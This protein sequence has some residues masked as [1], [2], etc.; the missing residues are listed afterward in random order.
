[1]RDSTFIQDWIQQA[2]KQARQQGLQQGRQEGAQQK[3]QSV[4]I[5]QLRAKFG[6]LP[7]SAERQIRAITAEDEL[8]Q[9]CIR[10][11]TANS[12]DEMGLNGVGRTGK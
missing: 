6:R 11:L 9:L 7:R 5:R 12:L 4:L 8:D 1:M 3:A 10:V 2:E